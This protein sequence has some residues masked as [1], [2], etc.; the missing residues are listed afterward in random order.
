TLPLRKSR[1][2]RLMMSSANA[3]MCCSLVNM[4]KL[5]M[6]KCGKKL[7]NTAGG[8]VT[9]GIKRKIGDL[10]LEQLTISSVH[11]KAGEIR[12]YVGMFTVVDEASSENPP[13]C[14]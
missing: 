4:I 11:N 3:P 6:K 7:M 10:Y 9:F 2:I 14:R 8:K 1:D 12:N 13:A 5:F